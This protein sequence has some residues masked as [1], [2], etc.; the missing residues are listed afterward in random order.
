[1]VK[2]MNG[3]YASGSEELHYTSGDILRE[4]SSEFSSGAEALSHCLRCN[5]LGPIW[6][7]GT[8][9]LKD[10]LAITALPHCG[11]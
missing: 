1:M 7:S 4:H 3:S 6:T 8:N 10:S 2:E 9:G 11:L 5:E